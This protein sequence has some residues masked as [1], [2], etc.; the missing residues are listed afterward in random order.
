MYLP[1]PQK[2][3]LKTHYHHGL[4]PLKNLKWFLMS[5]NFRLALLLRCVSSCTPHPTP[6]GTLQI[7][8]TMTACL[9]SSQDSK[10][11]VG[12]ERHR[13]RKSGPTCLSK[14]THYRLIQATSCPPPSLI[15]QRLPLTTSY[16]RYTLRLPQAVHGRNSCRDTPASSLVSHVLQDCCLWPTLYSGNKHQAKSPP[17]IHRGHGS[18]CPGEP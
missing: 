15:L 3:L 14:D 4:L 18:S 6:S 2:V 16:P 5:M 12:E 1:L 7:I 11:S 10:Q 13:S 8:I 9:Y 17:K